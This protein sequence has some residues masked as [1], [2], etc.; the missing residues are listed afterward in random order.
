LRAIDW[1]WIFGI[2]MFAGLIEY[3]VT[4]RNE[5]EIVNEE[6]NHLIKRVRKLEDK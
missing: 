4:C 6:L 2:G 3:L 1:F 5:I